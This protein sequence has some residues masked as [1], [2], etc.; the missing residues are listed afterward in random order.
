MRARLKPVT[1]GGGQERGMRSGTLPTHQ[2]VGFG[3]A[4][5]LAAKY[6]VTEPPRLERLRDRLWQG[7]GR[8]E[9]VHLNG[10]APPRPPGI[11]HVSF[12]RGE[13]QSLV[14]PLRS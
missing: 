4:C 14:T 2:I 7:L 1:F 6:L 10:E 11:V 9:G 13:G 8:L 5:A 3:A 12:E